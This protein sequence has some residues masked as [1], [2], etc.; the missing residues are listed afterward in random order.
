MN[1]QRNKLSG[2]PSTLGRGYR[3]VRHHAIGPASPEAFDEVFANLARRESSHAQTRAATARPIDA[4]QF[5]DLAVEMDR[6][7]ERLAQ[8]LRDID[9]GTASE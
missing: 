9:G 6:Q 4:T 2:A 7:H 5:R 1:S 3:T 8:L